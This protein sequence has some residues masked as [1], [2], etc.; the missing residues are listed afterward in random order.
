MSDL[1]GNPEDRFSHNEAHFQAT[2]ML[3]NTLLGVTEL[4]LTVQRNLLKVF[5]P[6]L[7]N[8]LQPSELIDHLFSRD[9]ISGT[10][11]EEIECE[12]KNRGSSAAS[13]ML[14]DRIPRRIHN[15]YSE[16]VSALRACGFEFLAD[17]IDITDVTPSSPSSGLFAYFSQF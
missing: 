7:I 14:L 15:W 4:D 17:K 13:L 5:I 12:L 16:F 10:D 8:N 11:K 6:E 2:N 1:V 9:V 3:P